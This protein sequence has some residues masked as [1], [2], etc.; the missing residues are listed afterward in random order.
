MTEG[1]EWGVLGLSR[2]QNA[3]DAESAEVVQEVSLA[4]SEF[5]KDP[6]NAPGT[7]R[8]RGATGQRY[9]GA[10]A[11]RLPYGWIVTYQL[12]PDGLLPLAG[13]IIM[14]RAAVRL[15]PYEATESEAPKEDQPPTA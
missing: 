9:P 5:A 6:E 10:R 14:L 1:A 4:F 2:L 3:L 11:V 8:L 15:W 13:P 7:F 12:H